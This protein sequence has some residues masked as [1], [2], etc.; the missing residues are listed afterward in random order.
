MHSEDSNDVHKVTGPVCDS[1][2]S[3]PVFTAAAFSCIELDASSLRFIFVPSIGDSQI[4]ALFVRELE[5]PS[6][7]MMQKL[8]IRLQQVMRHVT[9]VEQTS[10]HFR[11]SLLQY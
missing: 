5:K 9:Q 2:R 6:H 1:T 3:R 10:Q 8:I 11:C 4:R 7:S